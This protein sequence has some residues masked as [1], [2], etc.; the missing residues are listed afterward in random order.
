LRQTAQRLNLPFGDRHMTF[1][2]RRAQE[3]GKWA[4]HEGLGSAFHNAV[5]R[6]YF[7][8]GRNIHRLNVL[9]DIV[10]GIDGDPEAGRAALEEGRCR[11]AVDQDWQRSREM[12]ITAVP[13][14]VRNGRRL[15]GAQPYGE[16]AHF[17]TDSQ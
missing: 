13:T 2:S 16:L 17:L 8:E 7:A 15:V 11:D 3:L 6:A 12:G 9:M 14:F 10:R 1:N 5:F 4:E